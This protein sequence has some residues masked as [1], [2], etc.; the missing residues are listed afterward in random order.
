M[1]IRSTLQTSARARVTPSAY[2]WGFQH[3]FLV[4]PLFSF[5]DENRLRK[6]K[7]PAL[8]ESCG[9]RLR[10]QFPQEAKVQMFLGL[11]QADHQTRRRPKPPA[12]ART[13]APTRCPPCL[14]ADHGPLFSTSGT[15]G[16]GC[17]PVKRSSLLLNSTKAQS[18][19]ICSL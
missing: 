13:P 16:H 17:E 19:R 12:L 5:T 18:Q 1:I 7:R 10:S 11:V 6:A 15:C 2:T 8:L 9:A 4:G 3:P 14:G